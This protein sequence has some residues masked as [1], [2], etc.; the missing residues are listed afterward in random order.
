VWK[1]WTEGRALDVVDSTL[2]QSYPPEIALRCIQIGLLCVQ[3]SVNNRPSMLEVVFMLRNEAPICSPQKPAF[4]FNGNLDMKDSSTSGG[5]S[6][7]NEVTVTT[8]SA[9]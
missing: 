4:L 3:E 9:R 2:G 1:L 5:G 8:I 6:S 7:V